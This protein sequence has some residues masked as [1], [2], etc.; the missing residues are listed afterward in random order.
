MDGSNKLMVLNLIDYCI[1]NNCNVQK[2]Y[3]S[4]EKPLVRIAE[5]IHDEGGTFKI[6]Y[7]HNFNE[8]WKSAKSTINANSIKPERFDAISVREDD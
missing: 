5:V 8:E 1:V 7:D 6:E 2:I 4:N 3:W